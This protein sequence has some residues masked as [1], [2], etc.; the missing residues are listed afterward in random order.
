MGKFASKIPE[1]LKPLPA[2]QRIVVTPFYATTYTLTVAGDRIKASHGVAASRH[3][4]LGSQG[5]PEEKRPLTS[6][7]AAS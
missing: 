5:V 2:D 6:Y 3:T 1:W 7:Y 4:S